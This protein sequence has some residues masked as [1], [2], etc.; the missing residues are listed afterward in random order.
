MFITHAQMNLLIL[1]G[2]FI[3]DLSCEDS[4]H[5]ENYSISM[6]IMLTAGG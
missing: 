2:L 4:G 1:W 5:G 6:L 3:S